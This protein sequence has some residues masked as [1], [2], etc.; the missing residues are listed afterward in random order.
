VLELQALLRRERHCPLEVQL[1]A[2]SNPLAHGEHRQRIEQAL[3]RIT[4]GDVYEVN[5]ARRI[6]LQV[7]GN[8]LGILAR[9]SK[10]AQSEYAAA[11]V[12]PDGA[13]VVSTSPEL[14]LELEPNG[15]CRTLPIKGTRPRGGDAASDARLRDELERDP[16]ERAELT[17]V[18]DLERNDLGR[19]AAVGTVRAAEPYVTQLTSVFHRQAEVSAELRPGVGRSELLLSMLPSGSVTGAPKVRAM[20]LIAELEAERRGLYTGAF[21][22]VTHAGGM[23]LGMA[24]RT[25]SRRGN[26]AHYFAGGGIVADSDPER[27]VQE[28]G[29][30]ALQI[31]K[32]L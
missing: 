29:W 12:L 28:T 22:F 4:D 19:V 27:E 20:E 6:D 17:M 15:H 1:T 11:L 7:S 14:F 24:I 10:W 3:R 26:V 31:E 13:E 18:V 21:G 25:L 9:I 16:K 5:L 2:A 23:K 30:K 8:A 32:A